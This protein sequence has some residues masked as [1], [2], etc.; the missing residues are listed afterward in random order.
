MQSVEKRRRECVSRANRV[1]HFYRVSRKTEQSS[2]HVDS[3]SCITQSD[4]D[5]LYAV[6]GGPVS[7]KLFQAEWLFAEDSLKQQLRLG[8][9]QLENSGGAGEILNQD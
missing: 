4:A 2:A 7:T 5:C 3:A 8:I 1:D 6:G 9:V